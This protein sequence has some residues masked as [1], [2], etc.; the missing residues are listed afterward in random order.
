MAPCQLK[1]QKNTQ[2]RIKLLK[3]MKEN[4]LPD[5]NDFPLP[6]VQSN[7]FLRKAEMKRCVSGLTCVVP[8]GSEV[9]V[10]VPV[11]TPPVQTED[12]KF[13]VDRAVTALPNHGAHVRG[14]A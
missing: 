4:V 2:R 14:T 1:P 11:A 12:V 6:S 13:G 9:E 3:G 5:D 7:E 8:S 10:A